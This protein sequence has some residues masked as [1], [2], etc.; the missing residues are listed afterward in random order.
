MRAKLPQKSNSA[1]SY[2]AQADNNSDSSNSFGVDTNFNSLSAGIPI[3]QKRSHNSESSSDSDSTSPDNDLLRRILAGKRASEGAIKFNIYSNRTHNSSSTA[4]AVERQRKSS[5]IPNEENLLPPVTEGVVM[6]KPATKSGL[7]F[8]QSNT[9]Y[10]RNKSMSQSL[11]ESPLSSTAS[12]NSSS[13]RSLAARTG[14]NRKHSIANDSSDA[15]Q[16]SSSSSSLFSESEHHR[17]SR[18][19]SIISQCSITSSILSDTARQQLQYTL[20]PD[21]PLDCD[22]L[23]ETN[24]VNSCRKFPRY[25]DDEDFNDNGQDIIER[26]ETPAPMSPESSCDDASFV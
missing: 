25:G 14:V 20:S 23:Y 11:A 7:P 22:D 15:R 1:S 17:R 10:N 24:E 18:C 3:I 4:S 26:P 19:S 5:L 8:N 16:A 12:S 6:T 2:D 21:L 9:A 13:L